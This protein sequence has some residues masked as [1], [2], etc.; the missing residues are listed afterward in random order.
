MLLYTYIHILAH[1]L[2]PSTCLCVCFSSSLQSDGQSF[3]SSQ[4][5]RNM[6]EKEVTTEQTQGQI[7]ICHCAQRVHSRARENLVAVVIL[8]PKPNLPVICVPCFELSQNMIGIVLLLS[9]AST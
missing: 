8:T 7:E 2:D 9:Q 1:I 3:H 6:V 4:Q 5:P